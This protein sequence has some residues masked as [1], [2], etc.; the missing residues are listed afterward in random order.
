MRYLFSFLTAIIS[1]SACAGTFVSGGIVYSFTDNFREVAV[2][3]NIVDGIN[4]Y[5]GIY[6]IPSVVNY[7]GENYL[8]TA[9]TESAF[10]HSKVTEV[11][12]PNSVTRIEENAFAFATELTDVTLPLELTAIPD[13]CFTGTGIV[14]IVLPE[15]IQD[16]GVGAFK[17]CAM[18][19]TVMLPSSL[20][21]I[22]DFA[23]DGCHNLYEMYCAATEAPIT[24]GDNTF[25]GLQNV[26]LVV[27]DDETI[28]SYTDDT[29][30]GNDDTFTLFPNE[31]F[32]PT[33]EFNGETFNQDWKKITL[34][35][36]LAYKIY[37]ENDELV[38]VTSA[39]HFY[40]L[41]K[42]HDTDYTIVPTTLMF[43]SDPF[44]V[45][46]DKTTGIEQFI[47]NAFPAEPEP[48]IVAHYGTIYIYG[49]TYKRWTYV[50]DIYGR[51][52]YQRISSDAQVIDLPRNRVYVV[53][54]GN[55][56]KKIFV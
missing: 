36:N 13:Y 8:V 5:E 45:T 52:Y 12:I 4:A 43:D 2:D 47:D 15:G 50:W 51:L 9:I 6:I 27:T 49:D 16:V 23:F 48:I 10:A 30:W 46:V 56:V 42:D 17:D 26:D 3:Q 53:K 25:G 33:M 7:E 29:M 35:N 39:S 41:A 54:V 34:G 19:H 22:D 21:Y 31:D 38:A 24:L 40:L 20:K 28:D 18:L 37:D 11:V 32:Y 14:N 1:I 44:T 55:Y